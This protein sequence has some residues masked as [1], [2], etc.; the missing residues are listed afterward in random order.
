MHCESLRGS[1]DRCRVWPQHRPG[2]RLKEGAS[3]TCGASGSSHQGSSFEVERQKHPKT[4]KIFDYL[5][6]FNLL[7]E[8]SREKPRDLR[9]FIYVHLLF[10]IL[11]SRLFMQCASGV[12][13]SSP[14]FHR[15]FMDRNGEFTWSFFCCVWPASQD[16]PRFILCWMLPTFASARKHVCVCFCVL[17]SINTWAGQR[18][19]QN[20]SLWASKSLL[21]ESTDRFWDWKSVC[22]SSFCLWSQM[23]RCWNTLTPSDWQTSCGSK[24][25][26]FCKL[27]IWA[28]KC[29]K[30]AHGPGQTV[31]T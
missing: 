13:H 15:S 26:N 1:R 10:E 16:M 29:K 2:L 19:R 30:T 23:S 25:I 17:S 22:C 8:S 3:S 18:S 4:K 12:H 5:W 28:P 9:V 31:L 7:Q 11:C 20:P 24:S 21:L 6:F 27:H 14:V